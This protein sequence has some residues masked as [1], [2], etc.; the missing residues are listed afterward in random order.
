MI[1]P[2]KRRRIE[3][4]YI[5]I[6]AGSEV[7]EVSSNVHS[8]L[9]AMHAYADLGYRDLNRIWATVEDFY[10]F[11]AGVRLE[12]SLVVDEHTAKHVIRKKAAQ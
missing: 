12:T 9:Q 7:L 1:Q 5:A 8:S 6:C 4:R 10:Q 3:L 2:P 11:S